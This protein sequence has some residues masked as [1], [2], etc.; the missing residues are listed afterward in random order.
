VSS[1]IVR[2]DSDKM[3]GQTR[4][5]RVYQLRGPQGNGSPDGYYVWSLWCLRNEIT[6]SRIVDSEQLLNYAAEAP[7]AMDD[8]PLT[9]REMTEEELERLRQAVDEL[10]KWF[11]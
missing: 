8:E 2:F 3:L 10:L 6:N 9:S 11:V 7:E 5:G 4:S 1:A